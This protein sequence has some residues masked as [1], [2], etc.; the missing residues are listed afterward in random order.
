MV[1]PAAAASHRYRQYEIGADDNTTFNSESHWFDDLIP[2]NPAAGSYL[3]P[4]DNINLENGVLS[5]ALPVFLLDIA[6]EPTASQEPYNFIEPLEDDDFNAVPAF[7]PNHQDTPV[8]PALNAG[9]E[10]AI[11]RQRW[12][13][14]KM[15][16]LLTS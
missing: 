7:F 13:L 12:L 10:S 9:I 14:I 6:Q 3:L 8:P 16:N 2:T 11:V 5:D 1:F 4:T 15:A